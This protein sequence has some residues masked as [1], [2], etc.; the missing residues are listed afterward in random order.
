MI[1]NNEGWHV[2]KEIPLAL[3]F[4]LFMQTAGAIWWAATMSTKLDDLSYQVAALNADKYSQ[5]D[6]AR[7]QSLYDEKINNLKRRV[8]Y[9]EQT[10]WQKKQ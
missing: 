7:D 1:H 8:D 5:R 4:A 6:A 9:M 3:L 10:K 2:G